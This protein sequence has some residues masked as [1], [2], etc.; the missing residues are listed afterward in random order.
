MSTTEHTQKAASVCALT[1]RKKK[2]CFKVVLP[3]GLFLA[4]KTATWV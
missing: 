2:Q 1:E 3:L 4:C